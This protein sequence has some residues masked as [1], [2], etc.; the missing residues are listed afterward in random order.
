MLLALV[1][2]L[3]LLA[4]GEEGRLP[5]SVLIVDSEGRPVEQAFFAVE[6]A[7]AQGLRPAVPWQPWQ[8]QPVWL[9]AG[10]YRVRC[11]AKGFAGGASELQELTREKTFGCT[12]KPTVLVKGQI[13]QG[14][15]TPVGGAWV[16]PKSL[17]NTDCESL[18]AEKTPCELALATASTVSGKDG[19]FSLRLLPSKQEQLLVVANGFAA[20]LLT[21]VPEEKSAFIPPVVLEPGGDIELL[22]EGDNEGVVS[23]FPVFPSNQE[24]KELARALFHLKPQN[25]RITFEGVPEGVWRLA[26]GQA[27]GK[28]LANLGLVRVKSGEIVQKK[29]TLSFREVKLTFTLRGGEH[30]VGQ[31]V[32]L[33]SSC[34]DEQKGTWD[35]K[36]PKVSFRFSALVGRCVAELYFQ[37]SNATTT[38]NLGV[39]PVRQAKNEHTFTYDVV[40][41]EGQ[42][43]GPCPSWEGVTVLLEGS[44]GSCLTTGKANGRFSCPGILPGKYAVRGGSSDCVSRFTFV[45]LPEEEIGLELFSARSLKGQ[46]VTRSAE[47]KGTWLR[48]AP[49]GYPQEHGFPIR[50]QGQQTDALGRFELSGL[51]LED[52]LILAKSGNDLAVVPVIRGDFDS[53]LHLTLEPSGAVFIENVPH[54]CKTFWVESSAG[55][56]GSTAL[57]FFNPSLGLL[58]AL[59]HDGLL[60]LP[61]GKYTIGCTDSEG[62]QRRG[63]KVQIFPQE[64][65]TLRFSQD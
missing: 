17:R 11:M 27:D 22:V 45:T 62:R 39:L 51:P 56:L 41:V 58:P 6:E 1:F 47:A 7:T 15:G 18:G 36:E 9:A 49:A 54:D 2:Q 5:L 21:V 3:G 61:P 29:V 14:Q 34:A 55:V 28:N 32:S 4:A 16:G 63:G 33:F 46:V 52:G 53:E 43:F 59:G 57:A 31:S 37:G 8:R 10:R 30:L 13:V 42:L 50:K 38:L 19:S 20:Q 60:R 44:D 64:L 48:F 12:L 23:L 65:A 25:G 24:R 26:S 35:P 40:N